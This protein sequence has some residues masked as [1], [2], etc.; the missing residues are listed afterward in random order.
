MNN[1]QR[2]FSGS[3]F[4]QIF[5]CASFIAIEL[6]SLDENLQNFSFGVVI[7]LVCLV[8]ELQLNYFSC[9]YATS[10]TTSAAEI[11]EI[12]YTAEWHRL[13]IEQQKLIQFIIYRCEEPFFLKG[14]KIFPCSM[15]T[16]QAVNI[17]AVLAD[18]FAF[19]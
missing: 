13:P 3:F 5:V 15:E 7:N 18:T 9:M 12:V 4:F 11:G 1:L 10:V 19:F 17:L 14:Y 8:L 16:F 2:I 6:S